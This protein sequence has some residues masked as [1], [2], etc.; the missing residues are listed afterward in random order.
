MNP[1]PKNL[2]FY[3]RVSR[4]AQEFTMQRH[5]LAEYCRRQGWKPPGRKLVYA[6]KISG[7]KEKRTQLD[8]LVQA[9]RSGQ[10]DTILC[11]Q[12]HRAIVSAPG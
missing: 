9:A 7:T 10:V 6:E 3:L 4:Q 2:A 1:P 8:L 12:S 5:A 11:Y